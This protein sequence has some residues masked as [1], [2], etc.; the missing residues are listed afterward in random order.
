MSARIDNG[1]VTVYASLYKIGSA[2]ASWSQIT[3]G[4]LPE[5]FRPAAGEIGGCAYAESTKSTGIAPIGVGTNG[6]VRV[7]TRGLSLAANWMCSF[8]VSYGARR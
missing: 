3:L 7:L 8:S 2:V 4:T 6:A 1:V 5:Q